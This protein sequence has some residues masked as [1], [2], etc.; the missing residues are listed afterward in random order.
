MTIENNVLVSNLRTE[1]SQERIEKALNN[2]NEKIKN[3]LHNG[4]NLLQ[5]LELKYN[6]GDYNCTKPKWFFQRS[7][8][9]SLDGTA[10]ELFRI[11]EIMG[12]NPKVKEI[13]PQHTEN[14]YVINIYF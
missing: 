6:L 8:F 14:F 3:S 1:V 7:K 9:E 10:M 12:L 4:S 5:V 2:I 11:L 13:S